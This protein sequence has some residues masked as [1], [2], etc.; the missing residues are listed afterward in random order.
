M[1]VSLLVLLASVISTVPARAETTWR[2]APGRSSINFKVAH[3]VF[4]EVEGRFRTFEGTVQT[5]GG[6]LSDRRIEA[7]IQ[8]GSIYTGNQDRDEHLIGEEFFDA[9]KFPEIVFKS[10]TV[11]KVAGE[12]TYIIDGELTIKGITRAIALT[13]KFEGR[14]SLSDGSECLNFAASGLLNRFDYGL[15]WNERAEGGG[16]IVGEMVEIE[17]KI[18]LL[19]ETGFEEEIVGGQGREGKARGRAIRR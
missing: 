9:R 18:A 1:R 17:L 15:T 13:T 3:L 6:G 8:A 16:A 5:S 12:D 4:F 10:N 11:S 14:K 2:V 7:K 19:A